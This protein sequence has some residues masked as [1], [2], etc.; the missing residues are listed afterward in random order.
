MPYNLRQG[1]TDSSAGMEGDAQSAR[2]NAGSS[3]KENLK[4]TGRVLQTLVTRAADIVDD[5][6]AKV[7]LGL[8][9]AIIEINGVRFRFSHHIP[10]DYYSGCER[11]QGC[12]R[13]PDCINC[14]SVGGGGGGIAWLEHG[15]QGRKHMDESFQR[16]RVFS[17][18]ER[19]PIQLFSTLEDEL[20]KLGEISGESNF[21]KFLDH[22][23]VQ[24]R[25]EDV[26]VRINEARVQF[27][28]CIMT[29]VHPYLL[30]VP[31]I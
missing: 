10:T 22:K 21:R 16:V 29:Y 19:L 1:R 9:K 30:N 17:G 13:T 5:N 20:R 7:A 28:V 8:V 25:I 15:Q 12:S 24:G 3:I 2:P 18:N 14:G 4:L 31:S 27:E 11:Q 26:F 6:P 23:D